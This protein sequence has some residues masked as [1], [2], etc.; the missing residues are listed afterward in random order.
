MLMFSVVGGLLTYA[1]ERLQNVLPFNPQNL[2]GVAPDLAFNTAMSFTTNTNLQF[3]AGESTMSYFTHMTALAFHNW[4]SSAVGIAIAIALV[5]G[6]A[7]KSGRTIGNFWVDMV[8][9]TLY[10]LL[11]ICFFYTLFLVWQ[12]L[13]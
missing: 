2:D 5:R 8:R 9:G 12:G 13:P 11:P 4:V 6:L 1:I 7:R 10:V 3:Y